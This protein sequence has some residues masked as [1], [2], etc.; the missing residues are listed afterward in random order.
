M[1]R[2]IGRRNLFYRYFEEEKTVS[3]EL[4]S[5]ASGSLKFNR[6]IP[7]IIGLLAFKMGRGR[8]ACRF[9]ANSLT[10]HWLE[11]SALSRKL[12]CLYSI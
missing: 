8:L 3:N 11:I 5:F 10:H 12:L 2:L 6:L 4:D 1:P 9:I 7:S